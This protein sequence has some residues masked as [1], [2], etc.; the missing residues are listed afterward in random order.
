MIHKGTNVNTLT[1]KCRKSTQTVSN[2]FFPA[3]LLYLRFLHGCDGIAVFV[4]R[5]PLDSTARFFRNVATTYPATRRHIAEDRSP[6]VNLSNLHGH[7]HCRAAEVLASR[8][9]HFLAAPTAT[10]FPCGGRLHVLHVPA[11]YSS[12]FLSLQQDWDSSACIVT[13]LQ[14]GSTV[15]PPTSARYSFPFPGDKT[16]EA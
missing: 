4:D 8:C 12:Q 3:H 2:L 9:S 5:Q 13:R 16:A 10:I 14:A 11:Y 6:S 15:S 1:P 7:W